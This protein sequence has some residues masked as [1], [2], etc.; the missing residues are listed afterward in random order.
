MIHWFI[1]NT[2]YL[3]AIVTIFLA[4]D[5]TH[6]QSLNLNRH[7]SVKVLLLTFII[8]HYTTYGILGLQ[9]YQIRAGI[10]K[11]RAI[12]ITPQREQDRKMEMAGSGCRKVF[13]AI[14]ISFAWIAT[15][16]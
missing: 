4:V 6:W 13:A 11:R 9:R 8:I 10:L 15:L 3:F 14:Y 5:M 7:S 1:G 12:E 16:V 2:G